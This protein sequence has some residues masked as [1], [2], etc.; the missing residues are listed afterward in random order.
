MSTPLRA[1]LSTAAFL[2]SYVLVF[3]IMIILLP[4]GVTWPAMPLALVVAILAARATW[5]GLADG[6]P[7]SPLGLAGLGAI[8][9]GTAGFL[10]GFIGPMIFAPGANQGPMLGIF[11]TG[12]LGLLLGAIGG[13]LLG[14]KRRAS[15]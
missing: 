6:L 2:G 15:A 4:S 1:V 10:L 12:P 7:Q 8:T 9:V 11:I 14:L 13:F 3:F 5:R